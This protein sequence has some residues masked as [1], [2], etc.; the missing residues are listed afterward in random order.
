ME[1]LGA[2]LVAMLAA[3]QQTPDPNDFQE[4]FN[5]ALALSQEHKDDEAIAEYR[6]TLEL[7][8][9]LFEANA[10][11]GILL[12]RDHRPQDAL[13]FL[14]AAAEAK[15][16]DQRTSFYYADALFATGDV[17]EARRRYLA[18]PQS[19]AGKN[20]LL[21]VAGALER[22]GKTA[23]AISIYKLYPDDPA[24]RTRVTD[25]EKV[26][27]LALADKY[28]GDKDSAK[29]LEELRLAVAS[30]P[31]N[32]DT[33]MSFGRALRDN[34]QL[35]PASEQFLA[36]AKLKPDAVQAWNELASALIVSEKYA[37]GLAALDRVRALG[38][39]IP[40]D[41]FLRAITLDKLQQRPQALEAYRQFL[42]AD[43]GA[44][45]DQEFQARQRMRIIERELRK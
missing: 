25:L 36:A 30:D 37:E 20:G 5:R 44:H 27:H 15:P 34:K 39:E 26:D 19:P 33:R 16:N 6:R 14:K 21:N 10:N 42:D 23:D 29:M 43:G 24:V 32:F 31:R 9:G 38:K 22:A 45:P 1:A 8:P 40:G 11:L 7:K 41:F 4:H 12:L 3:Q 17:H 2:I 13:G 35:L 28:R 18:D